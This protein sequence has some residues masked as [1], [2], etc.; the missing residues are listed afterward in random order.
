MIAATYALVL[1]LALAVPYVADAQ[2]AWVLWQYKAIWASDDG[3]R[4]L[5]VAPTWHP[6]Q[7]YTTLQNC[8]QAEATWH[9]QNPSVKIES[10]CLPDTSNPRGPKGGAR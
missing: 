9:R 7:S 5:I 8:N 3:P 2:C 6:V 4:P 1:T 10:V